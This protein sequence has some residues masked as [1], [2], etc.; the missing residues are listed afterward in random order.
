MYKNKKIGQKI[1]LTTVA[2]VVALTIAVAPIIALKNG[3]AK[4]VSL[5]ELRQQASALNEQISQN[6]QAAT[7]LAA[8][9]DSLK[10][11]IS[12]Y[13]TQ[14]SNTDAQISIINNKL[15][16]LQIQLEN[17]RKELERQ[18]GLLKSSIKEIYK[19][20]DASSVELI[21][22]SDS[23]SQFFNNQT[24]L[25]KLKSGVQESTERVV[26]LK[27]QI[28]SQKDEQAKLLKQEQD[29]RAVIAQARSEK[30]QLLAETQGQEANYRSQ[31]N[32]LRQQQNQ[33][34]AAIAVK[35]ASSGTF[36]S[37]GDGSNGGYPTKWANASLDSMLDSWGMYNRECVSY[38]AFKVAQSGRNMPHWGG[39][40]N[41]NQWPGNAR[42]AGMAVDRNPQPG[43]V[44]ITSNGYYGH[45]MYVEA[46]NGRMV[47][48]SQYNYIINGQWGMY[49]VMTL[50]ADSS[51][52]GPMQFIHFP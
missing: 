10:T 33:V 42:A 18:K 34:M 23:F 37:A 29:S 12:E 51:A 46:V 2:S 9:G 49:S 52:L 36:V 4:A 41:A 17:A 40:G 13:D 3:D 8:Q 48:V 27:Q 26:A 5:A 39:R 43:D 47:T 15:A 28:Q 44:A 45:A 31:V 50:S 14:I 25:D 19:K 30:D 24:Y 11:K 20:G 16:Q 32:S 38:T 21:V 7:V 35:M 22:G 1:T 6:N